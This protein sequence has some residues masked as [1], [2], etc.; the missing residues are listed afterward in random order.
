LC[1]HYGETPSYLTVVARGDHGGYM[2]HGDTEK[3][4][5]SSK[6]DLLARIRTSLGGRAAELVYYGEQDGLSTGA[7]GDLVSATRTAQAI[8]CSYGM[9]KDFGLAV[10]DPNGGMAEQ[11]HAAVN[12][13]LEEQLQKAVALIAE[14]KH[15]IDALVG[16]LMVKNHMTG[17]EIDAVLKD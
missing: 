15:K 8:L 10:I 12:R 4:P 6:E 13:I 3:K 14:N 11:V 9:D 2:Q 5:L 17:D 1:W 7:S 16:T